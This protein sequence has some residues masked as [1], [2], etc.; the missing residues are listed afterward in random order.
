MVR[1]TTSRMIFVDSSINTHHDRTRISLPPH[2]FSAVGAE[3]VALSLQQFSIRRNWFNINPTNN[4]GYVYVD[5][6]YHEFDIAP[7]VYSTFAALTSAIQAA[8]TEAAASIPKVTSFAVTYAATTRKFTIAVT[9]AAG[10]T[11]AVEIRCFQIK[12]GPM[13]SGVGLKGGYNDLYEI[14]GGIPL[15]NST[16]DFATLRNT[17][18][19]ASTQTLESPY[20]ASLNTLDAIYVHLVAF[21]TGNFMSTGHETH[22]ADDV[23][24]I[25]SSLFARI[26]FNR[27]AF[28]EVH[29]VIEFSDAGHDMFQSFPLRKNF[30]QLEMRI[31]DAKG[32]SLAQ[33]D[34]AQ[35]DDGLMVWRAVLRFDLFR[36]PPTPPIPGAPVDQISTK[37]H[38][39]CL[40]SL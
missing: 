29:E 27:S 25:E 31:C 7:G 10:Q 40:P 13:P 9:M 32:R 4:T 5:S 33:L 8:L 20:P 38:H 37:C 19:A 39:S 12:N 35:A 34:P 22:A 30:E 6:T 15:K 2:P 21:E 24:L 26:P 14:L 28:D 3:R 11:D 1:G 23:R 16:D 18:G 17:T 36:P